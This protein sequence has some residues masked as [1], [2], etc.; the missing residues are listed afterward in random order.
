MSNTDFEWKLPPAP[1]QVGFKPDEKPPSQPIEP[2]PYAAPY[3][4]RRMEPVGVGPFNRYI[5]NYQNP[6]LRDRPP[7]EWGTPDYVLRGMNNYRGG[8]PEGDGI[9]TE[10]DISQILH[11]GVM[12]LGR[13]GPPSV[14]MP[15]IMGGRFHAAAQIGYQQGSI[16]RANLD[17][18]QAMLH[19]QQAQYSLNE[20]LRKYSD[21]FAT[22]GPSEDGKYAGDPTRLAQRVREIAGEYQDHNM[23]NVLDTHD[24]GAV[25]RLLKHLDATGQDN[26]KALEAMRL[27]QEKLKVQEE[28]MK[29]DAQ[30][31]QQEEWGVGPSSTQRPAAAGDQGSP[32]STGAPPAAAPPG[33]APAGVS[34]DDRPL[35][36]SDRVNKAAQDLQMEEGAEKDLPKNDVIRDAVN[37]QKAAL[38]TYMRGLIADKSLSNDEVEARMHA[39]NPAMGDFVDNLLDGRTQLTKTGSVKEALASALAGRLDKNWEINAATKRDRLEYQAKRDEI[40]P[41]RSAAITQERQRNNLRNTVVKNVSD[42]TT[43]MRLAEALRARGLDSQ[44]PIINSVTRTGAKY[45]TADPVLAAFASQLLIVQFDAG[46]IMSASAS[47]MGQVSVNTQ[48]E[49]ERLFP[50]GVTYSQLVA[51]T[52]TL[53]RDYG[54]KLE[55][56]TSQLNDMYDR[57]DRI[58][59]V[60]TGRVPLSDADIEKALDADETRTIGGKTYYKR[61]GTWYDD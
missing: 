9:P 12:T 61:G 42:M 23:L 47:G 33:A 13:Y 44:I 52:S 19:M 59:G 6:A 8:A 58:N 26:G 14:A 29:F 16:Q 45:V 27:E 21:A 10:R 3:G 56:V 57:I 2:D 7:R 15:M 48:K 49:V 51:I 1:G 55:P 28:Q 5:P 50:E 53:R 31:R 11:D 35:G 40:Q 20:M 46:R 30:K 34:T 54:N 4:F 60:R 36:P 43:L 18:Q 25:Q 41:I 24:M 32:A 38:D 37:K 22:W 17:R 39:A